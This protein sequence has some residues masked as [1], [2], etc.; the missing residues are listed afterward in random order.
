MTTAPFLLISVTWPTIMLLLGCRS[1]LVSPTAPRLSLLVNTGVELRSSAV[2]QNL[3]LG[4]LPH[5]TST[6]YQL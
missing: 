3:G 1:R 2:E 4:L 6:A 5:H